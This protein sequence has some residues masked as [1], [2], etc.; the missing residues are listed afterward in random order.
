MDNLPEKFKEYYKFFKIQNQLENLFGNKQLDIEIVTDEK[1]EPLLLQVRPLMGKSIIKEPIM[2]ER[3]VIDENVKRYKELIP[4]TDDRFGTNQIYSNMSDMNPAEMIGK[5]P[6]NI[7]FSLYR[8]MFTDTT[9]NKQ[10]GE[11][12]LSLIHI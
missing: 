7:A 12:G 3:S 11:F 1:E 5:K 9:W 10:R 6:D 8:F 2:V 4:T